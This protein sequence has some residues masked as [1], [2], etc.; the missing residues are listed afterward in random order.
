MVAPPRCERNNPVAIFCPPTS[1]P[2]RPNARN[3][4]TRSAI[5][6]T[7]AYAF[8]KDHSLPGPIESIRILTSD[9]ATTDNL[10][11]CAATLVVMPNRPIERARLTIPNCVFASCVSTIPPQLNLTQPHQTS[12]FALSKHRNADFT[13][14]LSLLLVVFTCFG[15]TV[16]GAH[17]H[18][19]MLPSAS[20]ATPQVESQP[21]S[22][23]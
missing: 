16:E 18:G 13:R 23:L 20:T 5:P 6:R 7:P 8:G 3:S 12:M 2:S 4:W 9:G 11:S 14:W 17:S 19:C 22:N 21:N 15:T 10:T 1:S